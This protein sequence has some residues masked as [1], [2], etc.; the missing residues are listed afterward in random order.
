MELDSTNVT[1]PETGVG[2]VGGGGNNAPSI[3]TLLTSLQAWQNKIDQLLSSLDQHLATLNANSINQ[4][5]KQLQHEEKV[6]EMV[7][8]VA[9][10]K[11][12][13]GGGKGKSKDTN[14]IH[15]TTAPAGWGGTS[16]GDKGGSAGAG[17]GGAAGDMEVD[18]PGAGSAA[19]VTRGAMSPGGGPGQRTRKRGRM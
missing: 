5:K 19:G 7:F 11:A 2:G 13:G 8:E 9:M 1:T 12:G 10:S 3:S 6:R 17:A 18:L 15:G 14:V 4:T 16:S